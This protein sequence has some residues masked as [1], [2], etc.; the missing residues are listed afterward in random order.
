METVGLVFVGV[1][2]FS[3]FL[4]GSFA[5]LKYYRIDDLP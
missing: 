1:I 5:F 4:T 2:A 3:V